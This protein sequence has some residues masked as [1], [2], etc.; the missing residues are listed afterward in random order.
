MS[1]KRQRQKLYK[2][3]YALTNKM[4][5]ESLFLKAYGDTP[6]LRVFDFLIT[7]QD[8]DYSMKDI[9]INAGVGYTTL[10]LFWND[11]VIRKIVTQT[12]AVGK[13]KMYK[14]NKENPEVIEFIKFYWLVVER[15]TK[16]IVQEESGKKLLIIKR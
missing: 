9:A 3:E 12:R 4:E 13:A 14:L 6:I 11:L 5:K 7:F 8:F 10:K 16:R 1:L 15:E 2:E